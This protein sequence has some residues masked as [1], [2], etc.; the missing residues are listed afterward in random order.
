M[1]QQELEWVYETL[2]Q[3]IDAA[4]PGKSELYLAKIAL[5][6]AE[7]LGDAAHAVAVIERCGNGLDASASSAGSTDTPR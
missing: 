2:A 4:G 3:G 5:A 7:A 1:T 6:L